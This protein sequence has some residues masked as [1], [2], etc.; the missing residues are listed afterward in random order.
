MN[1]TFNGKA[2]LYLPTPLY[3]AAKPVTSYTHPRFPVALL[4]PSYCS[5]CIST[6]RGN[7]CSSLPSTR[8]PY[9]RP[10]WAIRICLASTHL[11]CTNTLTIQLPLPLKIDSPAS[12]P[13]TAYS[14]HFL[15]RD[16]VTNHRVVFPTF[17]SE[18]R[19]FSYCL[20]HWNM[21]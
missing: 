13:T 10:A 16:S 5:H 8:P 15:I 20:R 1:S 4:Q 3:L 11:I 7:I 14:E 21:M 9:S 19:T 17:L 6:S 12:D 18:L 2:R